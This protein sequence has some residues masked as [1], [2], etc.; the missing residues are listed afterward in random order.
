MDE[1]RGLRNPAEPA[2][3][4]DRLSEG[5]RLVEVADAPGGGEL[6]LWQDGDLFVIDVD[7]QPLM[8]SW[9]HGSE[10]DLA[11]YGC[12]R[13]RAARDP[14]VLVGGLGMGYTLAAALRELPDSARVVIVERVP[15]VVRWNQGPI[16]HVAGRPLDDPRVVL[17][18]ADV[19][20]V[21]R[22][23]RGTYDA[24]LLDVD[25]GPYA[26][27]LA[28]NRSLYSRK[29]MTTNLAA[30]RPGGVLIIWSAASDPEFQSQLRDMGLVCDTRMV[31]ERGGKRGWEHF[32]HIVRP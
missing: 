12:H 23:D 27:S 16:A 6:V 25:N 2:C 7:E 14:V 20:D 10:D 5:W 31:R 4:D 17:E 21:L 18:V 32:L 13:L 28:Q 8:S 3:A 19:G 30:L 29:G 1:T 22:R 24:I 15:A 9:M 26:L 11:R